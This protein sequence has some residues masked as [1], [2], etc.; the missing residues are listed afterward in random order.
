M[1]RRNL[2]SAMFIVALSLVAPY[3]HAWP[4]G[5]LLHLHP[6]S[7][8][9]KNSRISFAVYNK[10]GITQDLDVAGQKYT[11]TP[12]SA[13]TISAPEGTQVIAETAGLGHRKGDVLFAVQPTLR[14]DTVVI[15]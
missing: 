11:V 1:Q 6:A 14:N 7:V 13:V 10:S 2:L 3:A 4:V 8:A 12:N 9:A 5:K 15:R